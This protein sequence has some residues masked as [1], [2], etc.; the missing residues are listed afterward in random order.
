MA[1]QTKMRTIRHGPD[2]PTRN[3]AIDGTH[4]SGQSGYVT[5]EEFLHLVDE[6]SLAE[7]VDGTIEVSSP[8]NRRHQDIGKFLLSA[9]TAF[10]DVHALGTVM[11]A[12]FQMKIVRSGREPDVMFIANERLDRMT[13][14][15]LDGPADL[16]IEIISPESVVRDRETKFAE[17]QEAGVAEYWLIDPR[18]EQADFYRLNDRGQYERASVDPEGIYYSPAVPGFWLRDSWLWQQPL[19][20]IVQVLLEIDR[21]DYGRYLREQLRRAGL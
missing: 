8:A 19:P 16:V 21:D 4:R 18:S 2:I 17:Y 13:P 7:W 10:V 14:T 20:D 11:N 1:K 6:D 5:Y 15:Y 9:L 3:G 12:P